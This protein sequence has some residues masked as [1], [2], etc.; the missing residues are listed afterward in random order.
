MVWGKGHKES[1][2]G[3]RKVVS[4]NLFWEK[5]FHRLNPVKSWMERRW[6]VVLQFQ[7][8]VSTRV[9]VNDVS[10]L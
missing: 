6:Q 2:K 8:G 9:I 7:A 4:K 10:S 1:P 5:D 3:S